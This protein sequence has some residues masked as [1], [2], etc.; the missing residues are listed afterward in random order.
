[1]KTVVFYYT[2]SG[3]A[4]SA[5]QNICKPLAGTTGS[6]NILIYK[7]II[8]LQDYPFPWNGDEFFDTF[9][10]TRLGLPPSG[11]SPIDLSDVEDADLVIVAGQSW[12]LS[13][14][15]PLQSFFTDRQIVS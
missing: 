4:L 2:Q 13:P 1:M 3:Q 9:P 12:F 11:I 8:P 10:E 7:Q 14:S 6:E 15:L 5:V